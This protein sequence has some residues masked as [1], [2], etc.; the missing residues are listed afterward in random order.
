[1]SRLLPAPT[2]ISFFEAVVGV[3]DASALLAS[4]LCWTPPNAKTHRGVAQ[5]GGDA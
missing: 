5:T 1:M 3:V 2:A 4:G